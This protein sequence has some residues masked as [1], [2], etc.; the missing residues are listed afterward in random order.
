M[1]R[2]TVRLGTREVRV[3]I[4]FGGLF[5]AIVDTEAVGIP[6]RPERLND[7]RCSAIRCRPPSTRRPTSFI[8]PT[9]KHVG[10]FRRD[11]HRPPTDP[12]AS[13]ALS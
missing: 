13:P 2:R 11:L 10:Y 6:L 4:A 1:R 5:Y 9:L 3:D 12:G 7:L 8:R